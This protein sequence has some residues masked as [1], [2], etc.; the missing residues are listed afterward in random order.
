VNVQQWKYI[1]IYTN[2]HE[3]FFSEFPCLLYEWMKRKVATSSTLWPLEIVVWDQ[4]TLE[5]LNNLKNKW[6]QAIDS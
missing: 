3:L 6:T 4:A 2:M 1:N 5:R